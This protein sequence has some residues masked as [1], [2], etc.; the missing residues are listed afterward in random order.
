MDAGSSNDAIVQVLSDK[1]GGMYVYGY[2]QN[3]GALTGYMYAAHWNDSTL[4]W[5]SMGATSSGAYTASAEA[6]QQADRMMLYGDDGLLYMIGKVWDG[7]TLKSWS[8]SGFGGSYQIQKYRGSVA[9][10]R[11]LST[12]GKLKNASGG[13]WWN[14]SEW[15]YLLDL[16]RYYVNDAYYLA[17][18]RE[19]NGTTYA[20]IYATSEISPMHSNGA[21]TIV[22]NGTVPAYPVLK[23]TGAGRLYTIRNLTTNK[24]ISFNYVLGSSETVTLTLAPGNTSF[25]N[26]QGDNLLGYIIPG[27]DINSFALQPGDNVVTVFADITTGFSLTGAM[28]WAENYAG[29]DGGSQ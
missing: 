4:L 7:T 24:R 1:R 3:L 13:Q 22:N 21:V 9:C 28:Q 19:Y 6:Y 26:N 17:G 11:S 16:Q 10:L 25:V 14:G 20:F 5:E 12:A 27:S 8:P 29:I 2:F 18:V 23:F 15:E